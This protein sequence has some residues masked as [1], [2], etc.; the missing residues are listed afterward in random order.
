[1]KTNEEITDLCNLVENI[2]NNSH[3]WWYFRPVNLQRKPSD[4]NFTTKC[5]QEEPSDEVSWNQI[6]IQ[7]GL[8]LT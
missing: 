4:T 2:T 5:E 7:Y 3:C 1:M 8:D 6:L